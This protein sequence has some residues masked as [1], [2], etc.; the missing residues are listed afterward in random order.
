MCQ[1]SILRSRLYCYRLHA[2]T[3]TI[4]FIENGLR[5]RAEMLESDID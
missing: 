2:F 5:D 4:H 3:E 1:C